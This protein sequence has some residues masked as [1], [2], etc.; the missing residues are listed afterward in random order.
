MTEAGQNVD[1]IL[2]SA[3]I[4]KLQ[5]CKAACNKPHLIQ[6]SAYDW[7]RDIISKSLTLI[8]VHG[9]APLA[10][11][12]LLKLIQCSCGGDTSYTCGIQE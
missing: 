5:S 1:R 7:Y 3:R 2:A 9:T 12:E 8:N 10:P 6:S 4:L 11:Q